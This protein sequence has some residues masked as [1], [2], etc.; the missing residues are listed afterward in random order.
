ML[1]AL[2]VN[3]PESGVRVP[4][5]IIISSGVIEFLKLGVFMLLP[6]LCMKLNIEK[7]S[8]LA[9]PNVSVLL[10]AHPNHTEN[11]SGTI[12]ASQVECACPVPAF[13]GGVYLVYL[14]ILQSRIGLRRTILRGRLIGRF[15]VKQLSVYPWSAAEPRR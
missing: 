12:S 1:L 7:P 10:R 6:R 9:S 4:F 11:G 15:F 3:Y 2:P 13:L 8:T 5:N 14:F